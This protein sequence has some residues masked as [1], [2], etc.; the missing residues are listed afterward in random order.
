MDQGI[1]PIETR[2]K[3]YR[4][5]SR[6]EARWAVFFDALGIDWEYEKEGFDLDGIYY[7]PDFWLPDLKVWVEI[8]PEVPDSDVMDKLARFRDL[9]G[10][11]VLFCG[12]PQAAGRDNCQQVGVLF[13]CDLTDS[14]GGSSEWD[15]SL[16]QYEGKWVLAVDGM[17]GDRCFLDTAF[18]PFGCV[19]IWEMGRTGHALFPLALLDG[20]NAAKSARFEFGESGA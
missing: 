12:L 18:E 14:S 9:V 10:P 8:K 2:Y 7:L 15:C 5:R 11:I 19:N 3:G 1:K 20:W 4:M 13:C 16:S 17:R 6:L